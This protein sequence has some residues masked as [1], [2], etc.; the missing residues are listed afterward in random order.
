MWRYS[1]SYNLSV[2]A[3]TDLRGFKPRCT[4]RCARKVARCPIE[5]EQLLLEFRRRHEIAIWQMKDWLSVPMR[6]CLVR[7]RARPSCS[8]VHSRTAPHRRR[9][10]TRRATLA[11]VRLRGRYAL[12]LLVDEIGAKRPKPSKRPLIRAGRP[13]EVDDGGGR[14]EFPTFD[15][16]TRSAAM[17][18]G[19]PRK[20]TPL[21]AKGLE[22]TP[23]NRYHIRRP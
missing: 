7:A 1:N 4:C 12:R 6:G 8:A 13:T 5:Y 18:P 19:V 10:G 17:G 22:R 3:R 23:I 20:Q 9:F 11:C 21:P 14:N 16:R 15:H 2:F